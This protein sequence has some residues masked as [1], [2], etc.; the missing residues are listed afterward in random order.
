MDI[1]FEVLGDGGALRFSWT[2]S[3]ELQFYDA[4]APEPERGF[5]VIQLGPAQPAATPY[6]PVA[7][8]GLSYHS[9][10]PS[11]AP[12]YLPSITVNHTPDPLLTTAW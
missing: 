1:G 4:N 12:F 2:R 8:I 11:S 7:G 6:L 5:T 9:A 3:S 10:C